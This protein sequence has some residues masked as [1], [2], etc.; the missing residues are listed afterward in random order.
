M[1]TQA[2]PVQ[3][4]LLYYHSPPKKS[5]RRERV[6]SRP[7]IGTSAH[8]SLPCVVASRI[9]ASADSPCVTTSPL[10]HTPWSPASRLSPQPV[11][12]WQPVR[13][14][15]SVGLAFLPM[16]YSLAVGKTPPA[17]KLVLTLRR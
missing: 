9:S 17:R 15:I 6:L 16:G 11:V 3:R 13:R 8:A 2:I 1:P 12:W 14:V 4:V 7:R 10:S 5:S